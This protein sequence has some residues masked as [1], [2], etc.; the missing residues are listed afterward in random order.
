MVAAALSEAMARVATRMGVDI[1]L[2][3]SVDEVLVQNGRAMGVRTARG[4]SRADAVIVNADFANFMTRHVPPAARRRWS[5]KCISKKKFSC[6]TFMIY[7][8]IEGRYEIPHHNIYIARDYERNL[9]EIENKHVLSGDMS[10]YV[11]NACVHRSLAGAQGAQHALYSR[12]VS[13]QHPNIDW[14]REK[15]RYRS[16]LISK[17]WRRSGS[18]IWK[19]ASALKKSPRPPT[20]KR[21]ASTAERLS[22]F[23]TTCARC[24]ISGRE[25]ASRTWMEC[26]WWAAARIPGS[27]LPVI[28]ESARITARLLLEDFGISSGH[29]VPDYAAQGLITDPALEGARW[30]GLK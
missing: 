11:Q 25:I 13:H 7:A 9:D 27:G 24:C 12:A 28:F 17:L 29:L 6:S 21:A 16:L 23:P 22:I 26:T 15:S 20:G 14:N 1:R 3:E 30:S 4:E 5:D 2:N 8:G 10:F 18:P 19:S